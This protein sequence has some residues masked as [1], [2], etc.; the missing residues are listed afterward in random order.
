MALYPRGRRTVKH[1]PAAVMTVAIELEHVQTNA[2][3]TS[4][5]CIERRLRC[6]VFHPSQNVTQNNSVPLRHRL[7]LIRITHA[8]KTSAARIQICRH[9]CQYANIT[10]SALIQ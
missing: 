5:D 9:R 1:V 6:R 7:Q 3:C 8:Q 10:E 4:A 2:A